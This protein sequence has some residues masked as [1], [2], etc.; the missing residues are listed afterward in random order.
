MHANPTDVRC[1]RET[2]LLDALCTAA[3]QEAHCRAR[4][5]ATATDT[6][7][8][9]GCVCGIGLGGGAAGARP[10]MQTRTSVASP[11]TVPGG[12]GVVPGGEGVTFADGVNVIV[13]LPS[14]RSL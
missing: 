7:T 3:A 8:P 9:R 2:R 4:R 5:T 13:F 6:H 1:G 11:G 12:A 14:S 10:T